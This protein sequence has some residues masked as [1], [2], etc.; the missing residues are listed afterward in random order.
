MTAAFP[1]FVVI[2]SACLLA[3]VIFHWVLDPLFYWLRD[4]LGVWLDKRDAWLSISD[5]LT[6]ENLRE[7]LQARARS[8]PPPPPAASPAPSPACGGA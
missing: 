3:V 8:S 5:F 2:C 7:V 4:R 6:R 1:W